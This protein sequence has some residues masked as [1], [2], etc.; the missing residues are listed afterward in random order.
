MNEN[1]D[2]ETEVALNLI[3]VDESTRKAIDI[4][5]RPR[6]VKELINEVRKLKPTHSLN[7]TIKTDSEPKNKLRVDRKDVSKSGKF[8]TNK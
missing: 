7:E 6:P 5:I 1:N 8:Q 4:P 2:A 3:C